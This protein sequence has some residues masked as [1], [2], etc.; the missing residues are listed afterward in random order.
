MFCL[1][2]EV[3]I[4]GKFPEFSHLIKHEEGKQ[5]I[6]TILSLAEK[7][8]SLISPKN[9]IF[10][11]YLDYSDH[12]PTLSITSFNCS[13]NLISEGNSA[14]FIGWAEVLQMGHISNSVISLFFIACR[15]VENHEAVE[16]QIK[17]AG[18][19]I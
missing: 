10:E 13:K 8:T 14:Y 17:L 16:S 5:L 15:L 7:E 12:Y 18:S 19:I 9:A 1:F 4:S 3:E 6:M 2:E 11:E